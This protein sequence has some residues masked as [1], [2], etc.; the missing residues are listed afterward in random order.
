MDDSRRIQIEPTNQ[1]TWSVSDFSQNLKSDT[2]N[3]CSWRH[4]ESNNTKS[5]QS[6]D[7]AHALQRR[8][9]TDHQ[10][11]ERP[12][13]HRSAAAGGPSQAEASSGLVGLHPPGPEAAPP[14]EP[15][16]PARPLRQPGLRH[17]QQT[18]QPDPLARRR[19]P[20]LTK[21]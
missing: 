5:D 9:R 8:N 3:L 7:L 18:S 21:T 12:L 17:D 16:Q 19:R 1:K 13:R 6:G 2:P 4:I 10:T 11:L 14:L 15:L 20:T